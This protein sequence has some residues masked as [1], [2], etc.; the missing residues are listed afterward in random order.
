MIDE[1]EVVC[2]ILYKDGKILIA[3][4]SSS[5]ADGI[6]EF[7]GGKVEQG[8]SKTKACIRELKE[9]LSVKI[10]VDQFVCDVLD[11]SFTPHV[12]VYAYKAHI[13]EGVIHLHA[14]SAYKWIKPHE[15]FNYP[16]QEADEKIK[17]IV[18]TLP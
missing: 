2:A 14:H 6:W 16:F 15:I 12:H 1:I 7:P 3:K 13:V 8:E 4:R 10:V 17:Q 5:I 9:E 18:Q 11:A